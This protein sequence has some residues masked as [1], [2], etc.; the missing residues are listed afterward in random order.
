MVVG[1]V[2]AAIGALRQGFLDGLLDALR[3]HRKRDY[4]AAMLFFQ[5]QRF[6][7]RVA[8]RLVHF[9]SDIGFADPVA[10]FDD[11][12]RRVFGGNLLDA[13]DDFHDEFLGNWHAPAAAQHAVHVSR[14]LALL[15]APALENQR[16]VGAAESER[17]R[18]RVLDGGFARIV[19]NVVQIALRI[20]SSRRL[21]VGGRI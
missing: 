11:G 14:E 17:I 12:E 7:E 19:G 21:I 6:F 18:E 10:A 4:F 16:G 5:A 9:E 20:G 13:D 8:I 1:D 15:S 3:A 2:N